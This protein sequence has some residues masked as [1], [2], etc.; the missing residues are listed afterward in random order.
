MLTM[1]TIPHSFNDRKANIKCRETR[2]FRLN[3]HTDCITIVHGFEKENENNLKIKKEKTEKNLNT[4]L[5]YL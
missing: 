3:A 1:Q 4:F 5:K 2:Q